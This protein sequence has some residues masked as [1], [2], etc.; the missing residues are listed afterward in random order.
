MLGRRPFSTRR[1]GAPVVITSS[2]S[3]LSVET[4]IGTSCTD[5]TRF[6]EVTT[7]SSRTR[8]A[9]ANAVPVIDIKLRAVT[10]AANSD[11]YD[12]LF[13]G[14]SPR[15]RTT[16]T[17]RAEHSKTDRLSTNEPR[18]V[19]K[20]P[21]N[22]AQQ[23]GPSEPLRQSKKQRYPPGDLLRTLQP[24]DRLLA[25]RMIRKT[26]RCNTIRTSASIQSFAPNE[27]SRR[28]LPAFS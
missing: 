27:G 16:V 1:S 17:C 6:R 15:N 11:R 4:A 2:S 20:K 28:A 25:K 21:Q 12:V 26:N 8:A 19:E 5:S 22:W 10:V 13:I 9:C 24:S 18:P 23:A 14:V 3:P 7:I